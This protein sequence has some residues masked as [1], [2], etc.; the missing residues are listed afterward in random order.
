MTDTSVEPEL[1]RVRRGRDARTARRRSKTRSWLPELERR[2]PYYDLLDEGGL[3]L[4]EEHAD[5]ILAEVGIEIWGDDEAIE[6]FRHA[7]ASVDG[8]VMS[9][10]SSSPLPPA[11]SSPPLPPLPAAA[12]VSG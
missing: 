3:D 12:M 10:L 2:I 4:I 1:G 11:L 5:R 9:L 6:L 8:A 7:G